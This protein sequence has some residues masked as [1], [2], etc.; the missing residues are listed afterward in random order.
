L[1]RAVWRLLRALHHLRRPGRVR[2]R[3]HRDDAHHDHRRRQGDHR[4][5]GARRGDH[6]GAARGAALR[7]G[8]PPQHFRHPARPVRPVLPERA[9]AHPRDDPAQM[10]LLS[11]ARLSKSFGGL[12]AVRDFSLSVRKGEIVSLIG[13]NGAGKTTI[14]NLLT[15]YLKPTAGSIRFGEQEVT[16]LRPFEIARKGMVRSF[17]ITNVFPEL[18]VLDNVIAA[19]YLK[20]RAS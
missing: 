11:V 9:G 10:E 3:L 13:P 17:Q 18:T 1:S 16:G 14:F 6:R 15:G 2:L 19:H 20:A 7:E 4:R 5:T 12:H 8:D